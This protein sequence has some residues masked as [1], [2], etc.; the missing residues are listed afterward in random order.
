MLRFLTAGESHG[1]GLV[2]ILEGIPAGVA[3]SEALIRR[4]LARRQA[5]YGRGGRMKIETDYAVLQSGVRHGRTLGSPIAMLIENRDHAA[6][7]GPDGKPWT[8]TMSKE[9]VEGEVTPIHRLRPG[10]ADTPGAAKYA[11]QDARDILE[12]SSA[13]ESAARVAVG[14][15]CRAFLAPFGVEIRSHVVNTGGVRAAPTAPEEVDWEAVEASPVRCA[16]SAASEAMAAAIDEARAKGTS[17]GGVF[18]VVATGLPIG[19][20]DHIQWDRKLSTSLAAAIGSI[21]AVKGVEFGGG[22]AEADL[23]GHEVQ[24]VIKPIE[25]WERGADGAWA[26]PWP[27]RTNNAGGLEGGMTTGEPLVLRAVVKPIATMINPLPSVDLTTGELSPAHYERS[28]ITF[29]PAC[30]VIGE[31]MTAFALAA[32]MLDKFGGDRLGE[33]IRNWRAYMATVGPPAAAPSGNGGTS[34]NDKQVIY[35]ALCKAAW[36]QQPIYYSELGRLIGLSMDL[37]THRERLSNILGDINIEEHAQGRPLLSAVATSVE[38]NR[39]GIG[40]WNIAHDPLGLY[41]G[42]RDEGA[43]YAFWIPELNK[44]YAYWKAQPPAP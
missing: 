43:Q 29:V 7:K 30:G 23:P 17:L 36:A 2:A 33:T 11:T 41:D 26:P 8:H 16:D 18:E 10:H 20:G 5:G 34:V 31:A 28:D 6:G 25:E 22:F 44:V 9:P 42:D 38:S 15:V 4:D 13:R 37:P 12:R 19:L 24:D 3:L 1:P 39:P 32:A 21:N 35:N 40:F 27:R 14:A